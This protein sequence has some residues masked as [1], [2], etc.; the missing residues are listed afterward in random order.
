MKYLRK[1]KLKRSREQGPWTNG[2]CLLGL[3]MQRAWIGDERQ[4]RRLWPV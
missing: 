3:A 4:R 2:E 1:K